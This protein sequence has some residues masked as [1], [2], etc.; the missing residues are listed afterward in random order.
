M[1]SPTA[2]SGEL[3]SGVRLLLLLRCGLALRRS[4]LLR[5]G[6]RLCLLH[7]AALLAKSSGGVASAPTRIVGAAFRLLQQKEKNSFRIKETYTPWCKARKRRPLA[8]IIARARSLDRRDI[9][10]S[11]GRSARNCRNARKMGI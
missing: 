5:G 8:P 9:C 1:K 10:G 7:H 11:R 2:R 4:L 6:L 3:R